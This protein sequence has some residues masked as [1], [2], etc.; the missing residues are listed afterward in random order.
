M[1]LCDPC[2]QAQILPRF[3]K[4]NKLSFFVLGK[5]PAATP[6]GS[7]A[8]LPPVDAGDEQGPCLYLPQDS[9]HPYLC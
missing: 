9:V 5:A 3:G 7:R 6:V 1:S 4:C 8:V 2:R